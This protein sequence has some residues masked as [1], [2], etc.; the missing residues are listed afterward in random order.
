MTAIDYKYV[1]LTFED[2]DLT[3]RVEEPVVEYL[4]ENDLLDDAVADAAEWLRDY[5]DID[6]DPFYDAIRHALGNVIGKEK[7]A[8]LTESDWEDDW[9]EE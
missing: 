9:E 7:L 5:Y 8:E 6:T 2:C 3:E 4:V 1:V